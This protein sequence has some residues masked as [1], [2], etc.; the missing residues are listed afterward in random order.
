MSTFQDC[1]CKMSW[2]L[3]YWSTRNY[4]SLWKSQPNSSV[5]LCSLLGT[6]PEN[7]YVNR[8]WFWEPFDLGLYYGSLT[9]DWES[10]QEANI[11]SWSNLAV[12]YNIRNPLR[13][14]HMFGGCQIYWH[15]VA[16]SC[17]FTCTDNL[18][19]EGRQSVVTGEAPHGYFGQWEDYVMV[20]LRLMDQHVLATTI[21]VWVWR[22]W[23]GV[24]GLEGVGAVVK[25]VCIYSG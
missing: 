5:E 1:L 18:W 3:W 22:V 4:M 24:G 17:S 12:E 2:Q 20:I 8:S 14:P 11:Y 13:L 21:H 7:Q 19:E 10:V 6:T 25:D 15:I 16:M 23:G 9:G